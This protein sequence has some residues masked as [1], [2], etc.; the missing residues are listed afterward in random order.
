MNVTLP[1]PNPNLTSR[2]HWGAWESPK[3]SPGRQLFA[4]GVNLADMQHT[5]L[6]LGWHTVA[7]PLQSGTS[8]PILLNTVLPGAVSTHQ[9]QQVW[10]NLINEDLRNSNRDNWR[11]IAEIRQKESSRSKSHSRLTDKGTEFDQS[12]QLKEQ[13]LSELSAKEMFYIWMGRYHNR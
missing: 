12:C 5:A 1:P 11:K 2:F 8:L 7:L 4:S 10:Q 13:G 6:P 9:N 3:S